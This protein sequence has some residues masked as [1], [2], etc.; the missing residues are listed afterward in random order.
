MKARRSRLPA[1]FAALLLAACS[2]GEEDGDAGGPDAAV[3]AAP[4][5]ETAPSPPRAWPGGGPRA[6]GPPVEAVL[7]AGD[8]HRYRLQLPAGTYL[9][10]ALG[11]GGAD[12]KLELRPPSGEAVVA[13]HMYS[14]RGGE[15]LPFVSSE[16]GEHLLVVGNGSGDGYRL[17]LVELRP[18]NDGDRRGFETY[19]SYRAARQR[20]REAPQEAAAAWRRAAA[21]WG[22]LDD[23]ALAGR[24]L[25]RLANLRLDGGD[26]AAAVVAA[27]AA[28]A[29]FER[30]G[31]GALQAAA[32]AKQGNARFQSGALAT[33]AARY[34]QAL[35]LAG[36]D[37][38]ATTRAEA[39]RG[40]GRVAREQGEFQQALDHYEEAR[41]LQPTA[42]LLN[43][44][45]VLHARFL[46]DLEG[47]RELIAAA[48]DGYP[49]DDPRRAVPLNQLGQ[50]AFEAGRRGEAR[51]H[52]EAALPLRQRRC[53][54]AVTVARLAG[55]EAAELRGDEARRLVA[56]A[57]EL[58]GEAP[59][60]KPAT[61]HLLAGDA[62]LALGDGRRAADAY[63]RCAE[64]GDRVGDRA[65]GAWC[66]AGV[67]RARRRLAD[68]PG[69]LAAGR[70][71]LELALRPR[72]DVLR[73]DLRMS[74]FSTVQELFDLVIG[75]SVD[76]GEDEEAWLFAERARARSLADLLAEADAGLR[77][78]APP[79]LVARERELRR[80]VS[81]LEN[82]RLE[83]DDPDAAQALARR[84]EER[85]GELDRVGGELRRGAAL[86]DPARDLSLADLRRQLD[87]NRLL[88]EYR[89]GKEASFL[90][91][92]GADTLSSHRL[93]PRGEVEALTRQ[94]RTRISGLRW[95]RH[96]HP[97][98]LCELSS[99]L[100]AAVADR[101]GDRP[102]V[103]VPDGAL[104]TFSFAA[105]PD[106]RG[107]LDAGC[108]A[109]Q[110]LVAGHQISY[111]PSAATL[112]V[113]RRRFADR[114][115]AAGALALVA[116]PVY[117]VDDERLPAAVRGSAGEP[118]RSLRRLR[119]AGDEAR[120]IAALAP[121][122]RVY[123]AV[124]ADA[125]LA[126]VRS[127]VLADHRVVHFATHGELNPGRPLLSHLAL[128]RLDARG[129]PTDGALYA[130]EIYGLELAAELV[131]LSACDTALGRQ[132]RGEGLVAGLPRAFL[133]AGAARVVVS[134]W[135]VDDRSTRD[136]MVGFYRGLVVGRPPAEALRQ[137]QLSLYRQG[138]APYHWAGFVLQGD[139]RPLP[140]LAD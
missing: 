83:T 44:L 19:L 54:R 78:D 51:A 106:P 117:A 121:A 61:T 43:D 50:L 104:E 119:F 4:A 57:L 24:A 6:G 87:G 109:A 37:G 16:T 84:I 56:E 129:R 8:E 20:S 60:P 33:A 67:A 41:G 128:S 122:G 1:L 29:A 76:L 108:A 136:L 126:T 3:A 22:E 125:S 138:R 86:A 110:P 70:A 21:T 118:P 64:I 38:D 31:D 130:H 140:P 62:A 18:A 15:L 73:T 40:L 68:L 105:L 107:D 90:W 82:R 96:G 133:Y 49:D 111:L 98:A 79:A 103:V 92:V 114:R 9:R 36:A 74:Y 65:A 66:L 99:L 88:L 135:A 80:E 59:C 89:L 58:A 48:R 17:S 75:L 115:P 10:A 91:L 102:L 5:A 30:A 55:V 35:E 26:Y 113:Q 47:G 46:G 112:A 42:D 63:R 12:L 14:T 93:P 81:A 127:G 100:L 45:G 132:V 53:D 69:A 2:G 27:G 85:L 71:A 23:P 137:A 123:R 34:R 95:P 131:T 32:L 94:A 13:D 77:R 11:Q 25:A 52:F 120:Q 72:A 116:D 139:P 97:A 7:A 39:L 101:L 28:A 124:G 134:L